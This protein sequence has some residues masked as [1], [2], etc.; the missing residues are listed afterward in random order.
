M[1]QEGDDFTL[2][3]NSTSHH[4]KAVQTEVVEEQASDE[5]KL[6][7][8]MNGTVVTHLAEVGDQVSAGQGLL[9]MEAMKME[10]TIEAPFDGTVSEFYFKPGELVSDGS[11]LLDVAALA[12]AK[13]DTKAMEA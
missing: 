1:C 11:L 12:D 5:D 7:A 8:P 10:Y 2:F 4:F 3:F 13:A 9:V 6:K